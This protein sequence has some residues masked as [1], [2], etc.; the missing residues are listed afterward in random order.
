MGPPRRESTSLVACA[1]ITRLGCNWG[2]WGFENQRR[3]RDHLGVLP[4]G[5]KSRSRQHRRKS[6]DPKAVPLL[7]TVKFTASHFP[8]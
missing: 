5:R 7:L 2:P 8:D 3:L 4:P 1:N 6:R